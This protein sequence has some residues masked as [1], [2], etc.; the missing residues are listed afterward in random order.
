MSIPQETLDHIQERVDIV[1]LIGAHLRLSRAGR[2]FRALCPFHREKTPSFMVS[3]EKQIF[4]CFG[5]GEGGDVFR[6][7]MK[8]ERVDFLDAVRSLA[9]KAGVPLPERSSFSEEKT[10]ERKGLYEAHSVA[11]D[12]YRKE[13][14]SE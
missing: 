12:Y 5:C 4:H 6:Y 9:E 3:P 11:S 10:S 2:N 7:V 1:E 8:T 13:L 14:L